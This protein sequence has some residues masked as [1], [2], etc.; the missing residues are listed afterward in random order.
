M[1]VLASEPYDASQRD[2]WLAGLHF[3]AVTGPDGSHVRLPEEQGGLV[4]GAFGSAGP[5][6]QRPGHHQL[7]LGFDVADPDTGLVQPGRYH[8]E[9]DGVRVLREGPWK[10]SWDLPAP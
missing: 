2:R 1:L 9:I 8:V 7:A 5:V 6:R 10:L 3:G 4:E